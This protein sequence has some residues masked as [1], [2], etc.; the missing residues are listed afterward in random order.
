MKTNKPEVYKKGIET[1]LGKLRALKTELER[2]LA[3]CQPSTTGD[4]ASVAVICSSANAI[5]FLLIAISNR[6]DK[7][8]LLN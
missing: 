3:M 5:E 6:E 4:I 2:T 7:R 8:E 1:S